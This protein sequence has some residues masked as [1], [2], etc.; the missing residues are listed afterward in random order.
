ML[1]PPTPSPHPCAPSAYDQPISLFC[2]NPSRSWDPRNRRTASPLEQ[3]DR[4]RGGYQ[5]NPRAESSHF[6]HKHARTQTHTF[7]IL[8]R[9]AHH[10]HHSFHHGGSLQCQH[11]RQRR[12]SRA[13]LGFWDAG[14]FFRKHALTHAQTHTVHFRTHTHTL[15][16]TYMI[17]YNIAGEI[18]F[19]R[20]G[21]PIIIL[22]SERRT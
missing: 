1:L 6:S 13:G 19:N 10:L 11:Q 20:E 15:T 2:G 7:I 12:K 5:T 3:T 8:L 4:H 9:V 21:A 18:N 16:H 14:G 17:I 22:T